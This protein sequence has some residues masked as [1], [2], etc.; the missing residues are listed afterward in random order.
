MHGKTAAMHV[1]ASKLLIGLRVRQKAYRYLFL[2]SLEKGHRFLVQS[3]SCTLTDHTSHAHCLL[4]FR[5]FHFGLTGLVHVVAQS[6]GT[7]RRYGCS[8][9]DQLDCLGVHLFSLVF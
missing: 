4:D 2:F 7:V 6:R 3:G 8:D 9:G 1:N 5:F